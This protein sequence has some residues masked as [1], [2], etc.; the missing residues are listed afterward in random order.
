LAL[1][2][3]FRDD[4]SHV[5]GLGPLA[6]EIPGWWIDVIMLGKGRFRRVE[7][8]ALRTVLFELLEQQMEGV[9]LG[10]ELLVGEVNF[11][12]HA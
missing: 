9:V 5:D 4:R 11:I 1:N 3:S 6:K 10:G 2:C 8:I 7:V 12:G